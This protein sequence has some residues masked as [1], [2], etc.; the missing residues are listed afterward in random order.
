MHDCQQSQSKW[1]KLLHTEY[2]WFT[3]DK[4]SELLQSVFHVYMISSVWNLDE[5]LRKANCRCER[6]YMHQQT[7]FTNQQKSENR[8][9]RNFAV[10]SQQSNGE[11]RNSQWPWICHHFHIVPVFVTPARQPL[12]EQFPNTNINKHTLSRPLKWDKQAKEKF[13]LHL[14]QSS[15]IEKLSHLRQTL[16]RSSPNVSAQELTAFL[17]TAVDNCGQN[18]NTNRRKR[19]H[20][21]IKGKA[22]NSPPTIGLM[23]N[24]KLKSV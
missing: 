18:K 16:K 13:S 3:M 5:N 11:H 12:E 2:T 23:K 19:H 7:K 10:H 21:N 14:Q 4:F 17:I 24:A 1:S 22:Q 15:T 9:R 8:L 20:L 6:L